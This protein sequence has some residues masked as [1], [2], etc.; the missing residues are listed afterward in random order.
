MAT[1]DKVFQRKSPRFTVTP[2]SDIFFED[3]IYKAL[4]QDLSDSGM[5]LL[6]NREFDSGTIIGVHLNLAIASVMAIGRPAGERAGGRGALGVDVGVDSGELRAA[7]AD[8][9]GSVATAD[10]EPVAAKFGE[11]HTREPCRRALST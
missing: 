3:K 2:K 6:C 7:V 4:V 11:L 5:L 1:S 8:V 9:D 10:L